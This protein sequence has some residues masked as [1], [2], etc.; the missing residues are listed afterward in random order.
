MAESLREGR[1]LG[2]ALEC[3]GGVSWRGERGKLR[4]RAAGAAGAEIMPLLP[5]AD[6]GCTAAA[7]RGTARIEV[8]GESSG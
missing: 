3:L 8:G 4:P 2:G 1:E 5:L 7:G 6:G